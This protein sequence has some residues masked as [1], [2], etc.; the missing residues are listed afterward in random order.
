LH[1]GI[2]DFKKCCQPRNDTVKDEKGDLFTD[3]HSI[4]ASWWNYFSQL[5]DVNHVRRIEIHKAEPLVHE[6]NSFDVELAVEKLKRHKSLIK[7]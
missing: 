2:S 5:L 6:P 3:C 4:L 1:R 7:S